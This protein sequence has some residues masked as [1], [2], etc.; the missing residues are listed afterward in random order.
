[1]TTTSTFRKA[2]RSALL[3]MLA[4]TAGRGARAADD[5]VFANGYDDE[6]PAEALA[7]CVPEAP[8][9]PVFETRGLPA[10]LR[11]VFWPNRIGAA[12][13]QVKLDGGTWEAYRFT[14][15][16]LPSAFV[17][18]QAD[19][20]NVG[21]YAVGADFRFVVVG[22]CAGD[23]RAP[24]QAACSAYAGEGAFLY[25]NF[26]AP[27]TYACNLDP[28]RAYYFNVHVG[29]APCNAARFSNTCAF[30]IAVLPRG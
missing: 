13:S 10:T 18:F 24:A 17:E 6:A 20:S 15:A 5:P 21:D 22:E 7:E 30:R 11:G 14:R 29:G 12:L 1:M 26:G 9:Y 19:T 2:G 3:A 8:L 27:L 23:F 28:A 16:D 4:A 25:V